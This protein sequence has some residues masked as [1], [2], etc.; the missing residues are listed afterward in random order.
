MELDPLPPGPGQ[1]QDDGGGSGDED[2]DLFVDDIAAIQSI[3]NEED[4]FTF[5]VDYF[6]AQPALRAELERIV[7]ADAVDCPT[8]WNTNAATTETIY[9]SLNV[10]F[11]LMCNNDMEGTRDKDGA[12]VVWCGVDWMGR[13]GGKGRCGAAAAGARATL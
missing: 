6:T 7:D 5:F 12:C 9:F 13:A 3:T 10:N 4:A 8:G 2:D 11:Q 1:G